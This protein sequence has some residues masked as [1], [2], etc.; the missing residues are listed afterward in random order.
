METQVEEKDKKTI[1]EKRIKREE[2][3]TWEK[4][5]GKREKKERKKGGKERKAG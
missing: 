1:L 4:K 3:N 5:K 2:G